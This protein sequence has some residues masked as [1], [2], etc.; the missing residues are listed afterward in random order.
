LRVCQIIRVPLI[1]KKETT[2]T[3]LSCI[4]SGKRKC[5]KSIW[6]ET[7]IWENSTYRPRKT[8]KLVRKRTFQENHERHDHGNVRREQCVW[9]GDWDRLHVS[10]LRFCSF[11]VDERHD[12]ERH[13]HG[14]VRTEQW[15]G[16]WDRRHVCTVR[17][18]SIVA[19]EEKRL[20]YWPKV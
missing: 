14:N 2:N 16:D 10:R 4:T 17:H 3:C 18:K 11:D 15:G 5:A 20:W 8:Q 13:D 19:T 6:I 12:H 7:A 1:S 9:G